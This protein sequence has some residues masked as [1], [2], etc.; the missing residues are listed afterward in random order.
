MLRLKQSP[1]VSQNCAASPLINV[2]NHQKRQNKDA[3]VDLVGIV[4][5]CE[6]KHEKCLFKPLS[7]CNSN[8]ISSALKMFQVPAA[9]QVCE[10]LGLR[11]A[12]KLFSIGR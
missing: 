7:P 10:W 6:S 1:F 9:P 5:L 3:K 12:R 2:Q 4:S 8:A 11:K